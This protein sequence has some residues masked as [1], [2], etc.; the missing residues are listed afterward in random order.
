[1]LNS[2]ELDLEKIE[3]QLRLKNSGLIAALCELPSMNLIAL[4]Q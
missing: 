4:A 2:W 3:Y 1:M